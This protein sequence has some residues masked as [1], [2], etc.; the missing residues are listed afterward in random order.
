[1]KVSCLFQLIIVHYVLPYL[2]FEKIFHEWH[3]GLNALIP[4]SEVYVARAEKK[5]TKKRACAPLLPSA[6]QLLS[7]HKLLLLFLNLLISIMIARIYSQLIF[8]YYP[9]TTY[10]TTQTSCRRSVK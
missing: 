1:M 4:L 7:H 3:G 6:V 10:K 5:G 2:T 9:I 8:Q